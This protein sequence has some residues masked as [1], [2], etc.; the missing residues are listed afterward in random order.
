[1]SII[2][3]VFD[4]PLYKGSTVDETWTFY[5]DAAGTVPMDLTTWTAELKVRQ[6]Y[7][8]VVLL[9]V[10][11]GALT[12]GPNASALE[13]GGTAGT[14]RIYVGSTLMAAL[15]AA[16]FEEVTEDGE[17]LYRGRWDLELINANAERFRY[18][19]G[20]VTFSPEVT[21]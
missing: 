18:A 21:W 16:Q 10:A 9:T 20:T 19:M 11:S 2:P 1:M 13:L 5:E 12:E 17:T 7:D 14:V 6:T 4:L 15:S 8:S 3:A